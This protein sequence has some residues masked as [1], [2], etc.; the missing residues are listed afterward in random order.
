MSRTC[1]HTR[2]NRKRW[3]SSVLPGT[4]LKALQ[5]CVFYVGEMLL[6]SWWARAQCTK[7]WVWLFLVKIDML[8]CWLHFSN[9][10]QCIDTIYI[11]WI[12]VRMPGH[13]E[14][15][16][17]FLEDSSHLAREPLKVSPT[18]Q[19]LGAKGARLRHHESRP[20]RLHNKLLTQF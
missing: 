7:A 11:L 9:I 4:N 17:K 13:Q 10:Q 5:R 1:H 18:Q 15:S 19:S 2:R 8:K 16:C 12:E 14:N 3:Q 20:F 6:C